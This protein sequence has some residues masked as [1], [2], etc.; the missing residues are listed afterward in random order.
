MAK[1]IFDW[2]ASTV[3]LLILAPL[4][5]VLAIWIKLDSF[6]PIFFR[7]ERVGYQ[8]KIF[9]IH[10]FRTMV[11]EAERL[12]L[13]ITIGSDSRVTRVGQWMRKYK[14]DELPQLIDCL[15]YTSPSPRD[16]R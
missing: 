10:K 15:L 2:V 6:G 11:V 4:F 16:T 3:G 14:L 13:Q 7:Q 1:R 8:G 9:R 5:C 12:G